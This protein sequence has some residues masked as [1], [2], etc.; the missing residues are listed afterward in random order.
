M[1]SEFENKAWQLSRRDSVISVSHGSNENGR[2]HFV[3]LGREE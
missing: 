3:D 2:N 1:V